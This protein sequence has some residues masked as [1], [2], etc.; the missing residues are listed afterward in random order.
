M[1]KSI[2]YLSMLLLFVVMATAQEQGKYFSKKK[3]IKTPIPTFAQLK[4]K[5]PTPIYE[6]DSNLV[7]GYWK[8][9][10]LAFNNFHEPNAE[11]GFVSQYIDAS[12]NENT[13]LW[14]GCFMTMFCNYASPLVPGISTLDNFY[15]KQHTSGEICREISRKT[16]KDYKEWINREDKPLFS[17]YGNKYDG[18]SWNVQYVDRE[19]PTPNPV[20]TLDALNHPIL[21]WA[22]LESF[23]VTGDEG[24]LSKVYEPLKQYYYALKKYLR[25]GNGLYVTD[26]AGMDNATRNDSIER[27]GTAVDISA[28][29]VLFA[30]NLT[31]IA[32]V[33]KKNKE[34][35]IFKNEAVQLSKLINEHM[36]DKKQSF[37]YDLTL[38]GKVLPIKTIG[39]FWTL[40]GQVATKNQAALLVKE[41]ENPATFNRKHRMP[42]LAADQFKFDPLGGYWNGGIWPSTTTMIVRG[43]EKYG[44]DSLASVIALNH[45]TCTNKVFLSTGTYWENYAADSVIQGNQSKGDF[46]GWTGVAPIMFFIEY[47]IG[48]RPDAPKNQL[49]W[50]ITSN[51]KVGMRNFRFNNHV[52]SLV[53]T[54]KNNKVEIT[55]DADSSFKLIIN[56]NKK[57]KTVNITSGRN[58]ILN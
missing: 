13:F 41:I 33:L 8:A 25:Q 34:A 55:V 52:I 7:N 56:S 18:K 29:M 42:S 36:W 38:S 12:F 1:K 20:L 3:Y 10:E 6:Q 37:Y 39:S 51:K 53:A 58:L 48:L 35:N 11:N 46:V 22:E 9:W 45:L 57:Q 26:W 16:G 5:L 24:R 28:E 17:R 43:L 2:A 15:A 27:G 23:R 4:D 31:T 21:A 47:A 49:V 32:A 14:D 19:K 40:L 54:P 50:N 44:Y 30:N